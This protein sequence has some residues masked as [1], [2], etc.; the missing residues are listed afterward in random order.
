MSPRCLL[1]L[2]LS[3]VGAVP[4]PALADALSP[5]DAA[6]YH[7]AFGAVDDGHWDQALAEAGRAREPLLAKVILWLDLGRPGS[8]HPFDDYAT[9]LAQNPD[10]PN[11]SAIQA[12]AELAMPLN[13]PPDQVL[14]WFGNREP[15]TMP[16][17]MQLGRALQARGEAAKATTEL[18]RGWIE[19]DGTDDEEKEFLSRF[20]TVLRSED[21]VARLDRLL[22]DNRQDAAKRM[23]PRV[24]PGNRALGEAR[25][26]LHNE[27]KNADALLA[28]VPAKLQ[29]DAGV[30]YERARWRRRHNQ[31]ESIP[32][33]FAPPLKQILRPD[34]VWREIDDAARRALDRGVPK[35]AYRLAVQHGAKEGTAFYEGEWLAGWIALRFLHD[36]K[37]AT[38]HFTRLYEG[39]VS[40]IS[41]ARA[42]YWLGRAADDMKNKELA[43][44]WYLQAAQWPT[45]YYGQ[46]AAQR[47]NHQGPFA[48]PVVPQPTQAERD[49][50]AKRELVAVVHRLAEV[51]RTDNARIFLLRLV[52]LA[53]TGGEHRLVAELAHSLGRDDL[54]IAAAKASRQSGIELVDLLYPVRDLP[55]GDPEKA[56]VLAVIRQES[57]FDPDAESSAGALGLMQLMPAT[58][59]TV[60]TQ[61]GVK[62]DKDR[63]TSDPDYNITLGRSYLDGLISNY[64]GSYLLAV[65][66]YN[67][68]PRHI[69][70][71][72]DQYRDP[73]DKTVDV[74]DW[75]ESIPLS[76]TRNYVQRVLENLQVYRHRIDGT[77]LASSLEQDLT[78]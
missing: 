59:K 35:V 30:I 44:T 22:W 6:I 15:R 17:A 12:Q 23:L 51:D 47:S 49:A 54:M 27:A 53:K 50:F 39:V 28:R 68:G 67:A 65:A 21:H 66:G 14:A 63:L 56:L 77:Q 24:D 46:L 19:L 76:E 57:A 25:I 32:D 42:A 45:T 8:N 26:A 4:A 13:Y 36:P 48:V 11:Q 75:V 78:R 69:N 62:Y 31:F 9:F 71:W 60:A 73:R 7:A 40:P 72:I 16:G 61:I 41:K 58:A 34:L 20:G 43:Q 10:W 33:L 1:L 55:A 70:E 37:T 29:H 38:T 52:D 3:L 64:N 5:K 2:L 18:R 74:V